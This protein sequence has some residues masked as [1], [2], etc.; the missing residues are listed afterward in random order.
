MNARLH[1]ASRQPVPQPCNCSVLSDLVDYMNEHLDRL[2]Q[3]VGEPH[4]SAQSAR[5][6]VR[7]TRVEADVGP[8]LLRV[9]THRVA[10]VTAP[11]QATGYYSALRV[12]TQSGRELAA[13]MLLRLQPSDAAAVA[14]DRLYRV[15]HMLNHLG[16]A[17]EDRDLWV[18]TSL[19]HVLAVEGR[20]GAFFE[21][22]L[23]RC[24][25]G[26]SRIVLIVPLLP[27]DDIDFS[28]LLQACREYRSRGFRLALDVQAPDTTVPAALAAIAPHYVR[29]RERHLALLRET[30]VTQPALVRDLGRAARAVPAFGA[31]DLIELYDSQRPVFLA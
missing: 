10:P 28:R 15:L 26:A 18:H 22:V 7:G 12:S 29:V 21:D 4:F 25:L 20:H 17:R 2:G 30:G 14:M 16:C 23:Q 13:D 3:G 8:F 5:L 27:T 6:V 31:Q 1:V 9:E 11:G 19:R 24:G